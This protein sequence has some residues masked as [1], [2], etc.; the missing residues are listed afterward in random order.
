MLP[1]TLRRRDFNLLAGATALGV[2]APVFAQTTKL[3]LS[4]IP[5]VDTAPLQVSIAKGFFAEQGLEI[6]TTPTAGGAAG[7]P[8]LAAG[9]VQ[10][11]FSNIISIVLGAKQGLGFQVIA[12]G[13]GTGDTTPDLAGLIAKK[14]AP[15]KT[16]KDFEGKRIAVNTRNNVIWLFAREW[17]RATGGD[18]DKVNYMEVP[19]PQMTDAVRGDRVEAAFVVEPFL[20]NA[21]NAEN[22]QV[23]GWPYNVVMKKVPVGMY[24]A[25]KTYIDQN[26]QIIERFVRGYMKGV[27]WTNANKSSDEW[28][29]IVANYTKLPPEKVKGLT[30]PP[31]DKVVDAAGVDAVQGLMRKNGMLDSPVDTKGLLYRTAT[32]P[33]S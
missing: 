33:V 31:Y 17:V 7:L 20:S 10:I 6:D 4:T 3:R 30:V 8:A 24:A 5:I 22:M 15:F 2:A 25:T 12:M 1:R 27:D 29:Q 9:Q 28:I 14:G 19:F 23:V 16:G 11:T 13:A 21:Q 18:P 26:P 32:N